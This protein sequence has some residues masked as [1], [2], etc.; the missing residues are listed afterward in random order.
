MEHRIFLRAALSLLTE[1]DAKAPTLG[2]MDPMVLK[3]GPLK[4]ASHLMNGV[5]KV[6]YVEIRRG[7]FSYYENAVNDGEILRKN[8]PLSANDCTC[9]PVRLHQKALKF[10]PRGAI[11]EL[12]VAGSKRL[13]IANS[14]EERQSWMNAIQAATVGGSA[15]T[16]AGS[17]HRGRIRHV[18]PRSPFRQDL[19]RYLQA[20]KSL[21]QANN[22]EEYLA[23][24][25]ELESNPIRV[26]IKWIAKQTLLSSMSTDSFTGNQGEAQATAFKEQDVEM[27]V[28]QLWRDLQRDSI[29]LNGVVWQ[30]SASHGPEAIVGAVAHSI[31]RSSRQS[32]EGESDMMESQS[33]AYARDIML[34]G[35]RTRSG[36]DSYFCISTL[37]DNPGL[38]VLTPSTRDEVEPVSISV[39]EENSDTPQA[40]VRMKSKSGWLK[41]RSKLQRAWK[42]FFFVLSEGTLSF[43]DGALPRPHGLRGVISLV[44]SSIKARKGHKGGYY[45]VT[46]VSKDGKE[47]FLRLEN[48]NR[49]I[50]W[51]YAFEREAKA[52]LGGETS[53]RFSIRRKSAGDEAPSSSGS[54][55]DGKILAEQ[56]TEAHA[57]ML[58]LDEK[59]TKDR[60]AAISSQTS[61]AVRIDV[62]A[63]TEYNVCTLDPSGVTEEDT[64]ALI[65]THFQQS[66][67]VTGGPA[68][69][70]SRGE[71]VVRVS[72]VEV[73]GEKVAESETEHGNSTPSKKNRGASRIF[74]KSAMKEDGSEAE[75]KQ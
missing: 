63:C 21:K 24:L 13:W 49:L 45:V 53:N 5:W 57:K 48:K 6:K 42:A 1:R 64:W 43:Y 69:T 32:I 28:D 59:E 31:L 9:R 27:S 75:S 39:K 2:M 62:Q 15:V 54:V 72:L 38:V 16:T 44:D 73:G 67:R 18:S 66:F 20:Q 50:E 12:S 47:H 17:D 10:T 4:K 51:V 7:M 30:G 34:S 58:G 8:I 65:R 36:G 74:R 60:I 37:C 25:Q 40:E 23:G 41:K 19:R 70:I 71:E 46:I 29:Q 26:P 55:V 14:R 35:N 56:A 52:K 68:G 3:S 22:K 61:S 11:F 33:L